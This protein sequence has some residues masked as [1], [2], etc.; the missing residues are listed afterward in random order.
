MGWI[1]ALSGTLKHVILRIGMLAA[2]NR[3]DEV[4]VKA[5]LSIIQWSIG[6]RKRVVDG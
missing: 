2:A 4:V 6:N 5:R 3:C 1:L